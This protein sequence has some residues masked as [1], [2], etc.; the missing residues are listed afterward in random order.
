MKVKKRVKKG[1]ESEGK[2]VNERLRKGR[3]SEG[4]KGK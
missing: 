2:E 1:R 4:E 3:K